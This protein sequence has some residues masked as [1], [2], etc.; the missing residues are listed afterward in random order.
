MDGFQPPPSQIGGVAPP[1]Q[2]NAVRQGTDIT[3][4]KP[5]VDPRKQ[6][7]LLTYQE[8]LRQQMEEQK[9]R[10][11]MLKLKQKRMEAGY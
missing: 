9:A 1:Q 6:Q 8:E 2:Q 5:D 7:A 3:N 11:E 10:K 4:R